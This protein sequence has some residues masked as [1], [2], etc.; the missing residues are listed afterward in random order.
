MISNKPT[1][2]F[3]HRQQSIITVQHS[4]GS[5]LAANYCLH[6]DLIQNRLILEWGDQVMGGQQIKGAGR[7]RAE[8]GR[9]DT[10]KVGD[11]RKSHKQWEMGD[12]IPL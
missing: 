3:Y 5:V 8:S 10:S 12:C 7:P 1:S 9:K 11:G 4:D 2:L 6:E